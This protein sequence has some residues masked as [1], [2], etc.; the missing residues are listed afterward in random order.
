MAPYVRTPRVPGGDG[1]WR[2][3]QVVWSR[4]EGKTQMKHLGVAHDEVELAALRAA[5][6]HVIASAPGQ[7]QFDFDAVEPSAV[8]RASRRGSPRVTVKTVGSKMTVLW[9][10]LNEGYR[11]VGLVE[12]ACD[13]VFRDLVLARIIEASS[14]KD[15]IRVCEEVGY[16]TRSYATIMRRLPVYAAEGFREALA[17]AFASHVALGPKTLVLYDVTTLYWETDKGDDLRKSGYSKERRLEPQITVGLLTDGAGFPLMVSAFE[18]NRAETATM[19]PTIR[20]FMAAHHLNDVIVVADA[21]MVSETNR[22]A[23][24]DEN[25]QFVLG[26]KLPFLPYAVQQWQRETQAKKFPMD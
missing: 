26:D 20:S 14:K 24:V 5:A 7:G 17:G 25:L 1:S 13:G 11:A 16:P 9:E 21:G 8:V 6:E 18:G 15:S 12:A 23:L 19:M 3:V 22:K 10:A 4:K 2:S